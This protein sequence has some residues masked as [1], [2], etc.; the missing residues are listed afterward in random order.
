MKKQIAF[1]LMLCI[2][3]LSACKT[4]V[5]TPTEN[6]T[7]GPTADPVELTNLTIAEMETLFGEIGSW[8]NQSLTCEYNTPAQ[9]SL[10]HL[11]YLGFKDEPY[12]LTDAE[13]TEL[14]DKPGI[15]DI[16]FDIKRLPV[17]KMNAVLAQYFGITLQDV[18]PS[19]FKGLVYLESTNCYYHP[20]N[21]IWGLENF[22]ATGL[23][24]LSD[25][26]VR[27]CYE[28]SDG[29]ACVAMLKPCGEGYQI[30]SNK[31]VGHPGIAGDILLKEYEALFS[32]PTNWYCM[33]LTSEYEN[34]AKVD[35]K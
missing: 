10:Y 4:P 12:A 22:K 34:P 26:T 16:H 19:A 6:P 23:E 11:F 20:A 31:I 35:L 5:E 18:D 32:N 17:D 8:Y 7:E 3:L 29:V 14:Q 25:G 24:L 13:F 2:F 9:I 15:I 33:A 30:L 21:D 1:L 28:N 27:M